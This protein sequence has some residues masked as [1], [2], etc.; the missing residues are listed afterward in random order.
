MENKIVFA[1]TTA[2]IDGI[3]VRFGSHWPASD[4]IVKRNPSLFS[5]DPR[6]GMATSHPL[7]DD[8]SSYDAPVESV[9][10]GP[11]EKRSQVRRG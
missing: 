11:G 1:S 8:Y 3:Y 9:T 7:R 5:D 10:A 4:E 6:V 2:M